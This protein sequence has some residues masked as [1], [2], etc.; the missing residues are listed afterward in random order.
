MGRKV[1]SMISRES[2][3]NNPVHPILFIQS[4]KPAFSHPVHP[5][6]LRI[7]ILVHLLYTPV[8]WKGP[9]GG[10]YFGASILAP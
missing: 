8:F 3:I 7:L 5:F 1:E 9:V 4:G 2:L 6:I 10:I